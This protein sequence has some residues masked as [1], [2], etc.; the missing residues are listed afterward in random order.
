M[1]SPAPRRTRAARLLA[2]LLVPLIA[3]PAVG[4]LVV[5]AAPGGVTTS[6]GQRPCPKRQAAPPSI[7]GVDAQ[8]A[9]CVVVPDA[10]PAPLATAPDLR[11][12]A[13]LALAVAGTATPR[14]A[15]APVGLPSGPRGP[16]SGAL[17]ALRTIV[18][19]V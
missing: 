8:A 1:T 6:W 2:A 11:A 5:C 4:G 3:L 12:P 9:P 17:G 7:S 13:P 18:L 19:R 10:D 16:P 15:E 14:P